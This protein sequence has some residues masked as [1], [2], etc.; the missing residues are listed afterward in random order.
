[1]SSSEGSF[2]HLAAFASLATEVYHI[3]ER[4]ITGDY[5]RAKF[6]LP[7]V[8]RLIRDYSA[9]MTT[10]GAEEISIQPYV[11]SGDCVG[12]TFSYRIGDVTLQGSFVPRRP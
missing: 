9:L 3:N 12:L 10:D 11:G 8:E 4:I 1:M 5:A 2:C 7:H 6:A